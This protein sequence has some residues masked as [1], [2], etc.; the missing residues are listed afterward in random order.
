VGATLGAAVS[1]T[2]ILVNFEPAIR[3]GGVFREFVGTLVY[4]GLIAFPSALVLLHWG[5]KRLARGRKV[6]LL[7][8]IGVLSA[9]S[10][11]GCLEGGLVLV[12]LG[13]YP[14]G[15]YWHEFRIAVSF[16]SVI[17]LTFG[18]A[19]SVMREAQTRLE[20]TRLELRTRQ[21]EE[22]RARKLAAE[23]RLASL[24]SRIHPH[25]LFNTLNS[26]AALIPKD[27]QHA[28]DM[29]GGLASLLRFSLSANHTGLVPLGQE[30]KTVRDYLK[31]EKV[32]FAARLRYSIEA[33]PELE[34]IGVPPLAVQSL[35]ENSIKHVIARQPEGGEIRVRALAQ[36]DRFELEVSDTGSGFALA[37]IPPGH[38]LDN[39]SAR[40]AL[41]FG[42]EARLETQPD[43]AYAT[44]RLSLPRAL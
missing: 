32:R 4:A 38:G 10:I 44:V 16:S 40:L 37:T 8:R 18:L 42:A 21:V 26:I 23:A 20:M 35:V 3:P 29:V 39:L 14:M 2:L 25:F 1:A 30:L 7:L 43:G 31:I 6:G 5:G 27:P 13:F 17:T 34:N 41:L 19:V 28:E 15:R 24:E 11:A 22:E 12:A 36:G 33:P 9:A